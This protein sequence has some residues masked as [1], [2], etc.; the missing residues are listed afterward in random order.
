MA[1]RKRLTEL[2]IERLRPPATGRLEVFDSIVPALAVRVT[3]NGAKSFVLRTRIKGQSDLIRLTIGDATAMGLSDAREEASGILKVCRAGDDPRAIRAAKAAEAKAERRNTFEAVAEAFITEHV[4]KLRSAA[5]TESAIRRYLISEWGTRSIA[6]ITPEDVGDLI[7]DL[8]DTSPHTGRRILAHAKR[9]FRWAAA[10]GRGHVK[11]NPCANLT[12]K[13][14][15]L[16][17]TSRETVIAPDHLRLIWQ[18]AD[19]MGGPFG[20][21]FK[22]LMLSGQRRTEISEVSWPEL[23]LD[24]DHVLNI[25]GS[26]MKAKRP[27]E[28]PLSTPMVEIFTAMQEERGKGE[29]I[30][31]T[32]NGERPISGFSKAK[33][34]LDAKVEEIRTRENDGEPP[35]DK[36]PAWRIHDIRRT[37]RTAL[38]ALPNV[39]HD[40]RELV[41]AHVPPALVATYDR[42][43]YREEKRQ[44][45]ELWGQRLKQIV[46]PPTKG[47]G[48]VVALPAKQAARSKR[49]A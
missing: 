49:A 15:D 24:G 39:P 20:Q 22:M 6:S 35:A 1:T 2:A 34:A 9:L 43:G 42:H 40:I 14:F 36:L 19:E 31:S 44:A 11:V 17:H 21:F 47:K 26:R 32:T 4:A 8:S 10:P 23:D 28:V 46:E 3:P 29:Y 45:L 48:N 12:A 18:A 41:I 16:A 7:R 30:F 25:P 38:G 13:D 5:H 37:V 33:L 27:H